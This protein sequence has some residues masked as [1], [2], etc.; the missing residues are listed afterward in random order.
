MSFELYRSANLLVRCVPAEDQTRWVVGFDNYDP[1]AGLHSEGFGEAFCA[2]RGI[3]YVGVIGRGNHW[4]QYGDLPDALA[5]VARAVRGAAR[6]M[7]Y[8]SSM[9]GYAALRCADAVGASAVLALSP[10]YSSDSAVVPFEGRWRQE[11]QAIDWLPA[12]GGPL[13]CACR[14][15][16][17]Y[18]SSAEDGRHVALIAADT[19]IDAVPLPYVGHPAGSFLISVDLLEPLVGA[20]LDGRFDRAAF[21]ANADALRRQD[22]FYLVELARRQPVWR[23]RLGL[24]LARL[25]FAKR[26]QMDYFHHVLATRL[27]LAG[28]R[29]EGL[30][31]HR[32]AAEMSGGL[33]SYALPYSMALARSGDMATA[34]AIAR[35]IVLR[36]PGHAHLHNWLADLLRLEGKWRDAAGE[37]RTAATLA[38][39]NPFYRDRAALYDP[40]S[41]RAWSRG[42]RETWRRWRSRP[43]EWA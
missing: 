25:A 36:N 42:L 40:L 28:Q 18:D 6:V 12:F 41:A 14:P 3:S 4:Y 26:P 11:A 1:D 16:V 38:P 24:A 21:L 10:Q 7:T 13:R 30:E 9:G 19:A 5:A 39:A 17:V 35:R 29:E 27:D 20:V 33:M 15:V 32:A 34:I 23:P 37:A 22:P 43:I 31:R 8:G 2:R